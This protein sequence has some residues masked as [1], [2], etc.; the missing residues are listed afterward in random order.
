[1]KWLKASTVA[2]VVLLCWTSIAFVSASWHKVVFGADSFD[3]RSPVLGIKEI[4]REQFDLYLSRFFVNGDISSLTL[5]SDEQSHMTD[6]RHVWLGLVVLSVLGIAWFGFVKPFD[7]VK[8]A[9][10]LVGLIGVLTIQAFNFVFSLIHVL[11]FPNGNWQFSEG[12]IL[13][14]VYTPEFFAGMWLS[15]IL[16]SAISLI[17]SAYFRRKQI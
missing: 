2:I 1:M 9:L 10:V 4:E 3:E 15:I 17:L 11:L 13:I 7:V 6:V 8:E 14:E 16:L 12:S 5:T